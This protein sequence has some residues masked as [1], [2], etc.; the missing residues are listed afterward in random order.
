[1]H[2]LTVPYAERERCTGRGVSKLKTPYVQ[3]TIVHTV[4]IERHWFGVLLHCMESG[5]KGTVVFRVML[6]IR[7][8]FNY[9]SVL[10]SNN[11]CWFLPFTMSCGRTSVV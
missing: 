6:S 11:V 8:V 2:I 10:V 5:D 7:L 3:V 1:M 9:V 4:N